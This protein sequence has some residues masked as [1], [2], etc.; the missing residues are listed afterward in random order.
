MLDKKKNQ[1]GG[2]SEFDETSIFL[3]LYPSLESSK[4]EIL[5]VPSSLL[6]SDRE[7]GNSNPTKGTMTIIGLL[8]PMML[9]AVI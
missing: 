2:E 5:I 6:V 1:G 8:F 4:S 9:E 7:F 3:V